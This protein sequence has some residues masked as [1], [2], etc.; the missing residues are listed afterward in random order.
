V[1]PRHQSRAVRCWILRGGTSKG[2]FLLEDELPPAGPVRDRV[3]KAIMGTPDPR[4]IDGLGGADLLTSKVALLGRSTRPDADVDYTFAQVGIDQD[5]VSYEG[6]CGN[7]SAAVGPFAIER[8]WVPA[9]EPVTVVRVFNTNIQKLLRV[10]V[11]VADGA[12]LSEGDYAIDGVPGTGARLMLDFAESVGSLGKGLCPTGRRRE[13]LLVEGLGALTVS[14]V[15]LS[16][17]VVFV[18]A[19]DLGLSG[20]ELPAEVER[21]SALVERL[22]LIRGTAAAKLGLVSDP[23]GALSRSPYIPFFCMVAGPRDSVTLGGRGRVLAAEVDVVARLVGFKKMHKTFPGTGAVCLAAA[24]RLEGTVV[25]EVA[26][27]GVG[28]ARAGVI[29]IG[30]PAGRMEVEIEMSPDQA[31]LRAAFGRTWRM[32]LEGRVFVRER[33]FEQGSDNAAQ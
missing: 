33:A 27:S 29:R 3:I 1:R 23:R 20:T 6:N 12:P 5:T 19:E 4:Q 30:H 22:E 21:D 26:R 7:I 25:E 10:E 31:P 2:V 28:L 24:A 16:N 18:R 13:E 8:G 32:L 11:P 9:R 14:I 15:D 17:P